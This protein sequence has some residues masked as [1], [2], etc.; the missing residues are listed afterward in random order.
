MILNKQKGEKMKRN[1]MQ[2]RI[3]KEYLKSVRTHPT[4]EEIHEALKNQYNISQSTTYRV[5]N[6]LSEN[7]EAL[8]LEI[9]GKYHFDG[10]THNHMHFYCIRCKQIYDIE[11][12]IIEKIMEKLMELSND[13]GN[14]SHS[15]SIVIEGTCKKCKLGG[16]KHE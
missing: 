8:K 16:E 15:I 6:E 10:Y 1:T 9:D 7:G 13:L 2:K 12:N 4:A 5:L 11:H 14:K 3:I